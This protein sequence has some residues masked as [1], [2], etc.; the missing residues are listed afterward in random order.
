MQLSLPVLAIHSWNNT[1]THETK[2]VF[3]PRVGN[4]RADLLF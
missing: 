2:G 4:S 3:G 1:F